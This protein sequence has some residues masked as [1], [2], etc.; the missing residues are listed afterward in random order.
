MW[1]AYLWKTEGVSLVIFCY[2]CFHRGFMWS[3]NAGNTVS[4]ESSWPHH[5]IKMRILDLMYFITVFDIYLLLLNSEI[6]VEVLN[7]D[8]L[9]LFLS[10]DVNDNVPFFT[11]SIYEA[12]VT[13]GVEVGTL[14]LQ[15]S[16]NDLD[17]GLNGKVYDKAIDSLI[18][19]YQSFHNFSLK[20]IFRESNSNLVCLNSTCISYIISDI[21]ITSDC[22]LDAVNF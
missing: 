4:V 17:L 3:R 2:I 19:G 15:V 7:F 16:A 18:L 9:C 20:N 22:I 6:T 14:V 1:Q 21:E 11:S 13:E 10:T 12:S 8:S 5:T